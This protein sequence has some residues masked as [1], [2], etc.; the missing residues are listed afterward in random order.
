MVVF[1]YTVTDSVTN[2]PFAFHSYQQLSF[3]SLCTFN[4]SSGYYIGISL[5]FPSIPTLMWLSAFSK[6]LLTIWKS[7][8]IEVSVQ[9]FCLFFS[10]VM[11]L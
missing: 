1:D 8:F 5:W 4:N 3:I 9:I 6:Y 10:W 2:I 11:F 7:S